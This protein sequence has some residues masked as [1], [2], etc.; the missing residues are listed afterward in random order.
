MRGTVPNS[1]AVA[2][3]VF[4]VL[5][6]GALIGIPLL[7]GWRQ[8]RQDHRKIMAEGVTGQAMIS[9]ITP[10]SRT[11]RCVLYFSFQ[12]SAAHPTVQGKQRTTQ[13]VIDNLGL[14]VGSTVQVRYLSK[15]PKYAFIDAVTLA[16]RILPREPSNSLAIAQLA[17]S[18]S[19]FYVSYAPANSLRWY[20]SGDVVIAESKARF[21]AQ[22]RRPF[23][24]PKTLE[25]DF[26]LNSIVNVERFDATVRLEIIE[27]EKKPCKLQFVTVN[28]EAAESIAKMLPGTKTGSFTPVLAEGAA[29]NSALMTVTPNTPVTLALIA[30]N[31]VMF[32]VVTALGG[33]LF[34][35]DPEVM[36]RFGTD[37]TP[38]TLAGQWWRLLT[39]IFLHFGLFHIALNMWALYV[40]GRVAERIFGSLRYLAIYLVAG[41][42]GSVA[43]LLWHPIVNGAGASGAIFGVLGAM[44]AFFLKREGGVPASVIKAQL[45]SVSVFVAYSLLNAA[46]YQ[47]IDNAA[48]V[49]GLVGG[50]VLGFILSRPLE[51]ARDLKR[52]TKQWATALGLVCVA[53]LVIAHLFAT[54]ALVPRLAHDVRGNAVPLAALGPPI[55][56]LGGIRLDMTSDEVLKEKGRPIL[57]DNSS[58]VYNSVDSKHDG[59]LTVFFSHPNNSERGAVLAIEFTGHDQTSA[60]AEMPYLNSLNSTDVILKYGEP[61]SRRPTPEGTTFLWF[62]NGI[63]I[64]TRNDKVYRYGIFDLAQLRR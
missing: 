21:T 39:S 22:Q 8:V 54:G 44:I 10:K 25:R 9:K 19:L 23:W 43:S 17:D 58:W 6:F 5:I 13:A 50:F 42:S 20:G 49:G 31:V 45:T 29:F 41:L 33:G 27:P 24:L 12:P 1:A 46:R 61:A 16:E 57:Q 2:P 63:Y 35:V 53:S 64:G 56:S 3:I 52:W 34:K 7:V 37:Y 40:N 30:V 60:P 48:H 14:M 47:G 28:A 62:R 36:I 59:V 38:L 18:P 4:V 15:W 11:G 51:A 32:L 55:H 26:A